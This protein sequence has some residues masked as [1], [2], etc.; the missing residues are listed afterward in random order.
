[1]KKL[2]IA[3][4]LLPVLF[5]ATGVFAQEGDSTQNL[6]I[7]MKV[8]SATAQ[9]ASVAG[10]TAYITL[11]KDNKEIDTIESS[12]DESG[13]AVFK[14][15]VGTEHLIAL[16]RVRHQDMMFS[17]KPVHLHAS[18]EPVQLHVEV[19]DVSEDNSAIT[20]GPHHMMIKVLE[21]SV[22][23][24]E[25]MQ[26]KNSTDMAVTSAKKDARD[27]AQVITIF[28]PAGFQEFNA[29][30]YFV[31]DALVMNENGFYDTMAIPPGTYNAMFSYTLPIT[32]EEMQITKKISMSTEDFM[33]FSQMAPGRL[34]GL[35]ASTGK[36]TLEDGTPSEYFAATKKSSG[37]QI[38][39][40]ITGLKIASSKLSTII[41]AI[42][43]LLIAPFVIVRLK[44]SK[45]QKKSAK[46]KK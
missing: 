26:I 2:S 14:Y 23:I 34:Q 13:T 42:V 11:Y 41:I 45:Q 12:I 17:S 20:V 30:Q 8:T 39:M 19:Y 28:L 31:A 36:L 16:A 6:I 5:I 29:T 22:R 7:N 25:F 37:D 44:P 32:A 15:P 27:R 9:G 43:F 10:D 18:D 33:V 35:G 24:T 3:V 21:N 4:L 38:V 1:M 40:T 46:K